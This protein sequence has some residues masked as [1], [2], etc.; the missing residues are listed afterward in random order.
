MIFFENEKVSMERIPP[1]KYSFQ[2]YFLWFFW[3]TLLIFH[4]LSAIERYST[5]SFD[6]FS[7]LWLVLSFIC[8][9][10]SISRL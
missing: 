3:Y 5:L 10:M 8:L 9:F 1:E 4:L 6:Y 7:S 2:N